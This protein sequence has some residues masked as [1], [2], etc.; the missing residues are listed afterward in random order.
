MAAPWA[1]VFVLAASSA[2]Q[3]E[4]AQ[5]EKRLERKDF[6]GAES[7]LREIVRSD[8]SNA[9]AH[10]N[11]ALALLPQRKVREA[12]DEGRLAAA[13]APQN[14]EARYIYGLTL[15]ASNR[16]IEAAR[17]F[18][19]TAALKPGEV[20]PLVALAEAYAASQDER[21]AP[22]YE[23]L[24]VLEP[25]QPRHR[26]DFA[27]YLWS[28][29][30]TGRGDEIAAAA[31]QEFPDAGQLHARYGRALFEEQR[32]VD[33]ARELARAGD[34]GIRD[35]ETLDLFGNA[36]WQAGR[37]EEAEAAFEAALLV[38][39]DSANLR[40][41]LGRLLL[42]QGRAELALSQLEEAARLKPGDAIAA[43]H[44]GRA[45]E[46][47]GRLADAERA[48]RKAVTLLPEL[49]SP[50]YA[51]GRLLVRQGRTEEGQRELEVH[52]SLYARAERAL[53]ETE[54]R[55]SE[56]LL[57]WSELARGQAAAALAR[58]ESLPEGLEVLRG[59]AKA[60]SRLNRH[61]E[62]VHV[63]ERAREL[64]PE[65]VR[66]Q[67]QLAAERERVLGEP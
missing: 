35:V 48:Y 52:R 25:Q 5:A 36:L 14:A 26:V 13:F 43:L 30:K 28:A 46:A 45:Q 24:L 16:N 58:F 66:I 11:L 21:A 63:L 33:A 15:R 57:A 64:Q 41:D 67:A 44:L 38:H 32:F 20:G 1:A 8:P 49:A 53:F 18:E 37:I 60:L 39:S 42:S 4:L 9:R 10:G 22:V 34:L 40:L 29:G 51:L 47:A 19:K 56:I 65:E 12:V 6:V 23:R 54:S 2:S 55:R 7:A 62:A 3:D 50:H 61:R 31:I 17:E 59:R 27:E